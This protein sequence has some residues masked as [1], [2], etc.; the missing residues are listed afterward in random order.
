MKLTIFF[1][2]II[3]SLQLRDDSC[4]RNHFFQ[5][6]KDTFYFKRCCFPDI[7]IYQ[8]TNVTS[9]M[10]I[11]APNLLLST[12]ITLLKFNEKS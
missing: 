1:L 3:S 2:C 6:A 7:V 5:E 9:S 8:S 4:Y 10:R 12:I 11:T